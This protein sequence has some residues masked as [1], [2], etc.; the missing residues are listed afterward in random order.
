MFF[1]W[2]VIYHLVGT[3]VNCI[4]VGLEG[5]GFGTTCLMCMHVISSVPVTSIN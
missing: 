5:C 2:F 4:I 1:V 3:L